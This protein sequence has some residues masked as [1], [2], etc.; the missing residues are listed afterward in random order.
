M[1]HP[2]GSPGSRGA[3]L[4]GPFLLLSIRDEDEAADDEYR[5]MMRFAGLGSAGM[6]RIRL[7]H[8]SLGRIDLADWSGIILGGGPYNVSDA[9]EVKSAT[10]RRVESELLGLIGRIV[11]HDFPFLGCCYGVGTLGTVIGA[12]VDRAHP[13]P[14]AGVT[15][16]V[17]SGG[18]ADDLFAD[19]PDVFDAYG[20][21]REGASALPS[22][23]VRLASSS[24]CPVQA[25]RVG[26]NVY[27]TQFHPELDLD[28]MLTRIDVYKNHGYFP[29]ESADTLKTAA[30]QWNVR[31]PQT[32]LKRFVDRYARR[33]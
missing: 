6:R 20:G 7:T 10:Q 27:A 14:V 26:E 12:T 28:G 16:A 4:S 15:V 25:F 11:E 21:H 33:R 18:R 32:I 8:E 30:R 2:A 5:A 22:H 24:T 29:P 9:A 13:E 1:R 17:T 19:V 3:V 23:A 31:Y